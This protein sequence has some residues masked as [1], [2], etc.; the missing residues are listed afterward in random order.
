MKTKITILLIALA[1]SF[2]S[3][4]NIVSVDT[5]VCPGQ[6]L[7]VKFKWD[8]SAGA[9]DFRMQYVEENYVVS[10]HIWSKDNSA[11]YEL[12]KEILG[13]DTIYSISLIT[14]PFFPFGLTKFSAG[15]GD[16]YDLKVKCLDWVGINE[17][18][19]NKIE[20]LY[21]DLLG[22]KIEKRSGEIIILQIGNKRKK[23]LYD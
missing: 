6:N 15:Y 20:P 11:F 14:Q 5:S 22:N 16:L 3:Q 4:V 1:F 18:S 13:G 12:P 19:V 23:V 10:A 9:T 21:F 7:N 2:K 17:L 8:N